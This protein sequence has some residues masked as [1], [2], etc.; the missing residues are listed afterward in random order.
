[1]T[2]TLNIPS[3]TNPCPAW[4]T[5]PAG[6]GYDSRSIEHGA[7]VRDHTIDSGHD[8]GASIAAS[9]HQTGEGE[10]VDTPT[11]T[12]WVRGDAHDSEIT[13]AEARDLARH[14]VEAADKLDGI[15][16]T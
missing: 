12:V 8:T 11:I 10:S 14:L 16:N 7:P 6:H 13:A 1:M 3:T 4:C 15:T 2:I 5:R 9:G